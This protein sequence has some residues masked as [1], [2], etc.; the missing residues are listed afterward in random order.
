[1]VP[2]AVW[3]F[4]MSENCNYKFYLINNKSIFPKI[5]CIEKGRLSYS[6]VNTVLILTFSRQCESCDEKKFFLKN[7]MSALPD[8]RYNIRISSYDDFT[9]N[10]MKMKTCWS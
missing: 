4:L 5:F 6:W 9:T 1:V 8:C 3:D 2:A 7:Q 10:G